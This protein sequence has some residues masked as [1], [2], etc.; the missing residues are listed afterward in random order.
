[1]F[2]NYIKNQMTSI[3][4]PIKT[5]VIA[6]IPINYLQIYKDDPDFLGY[7]VVLYSLISLSILMGVGIIMQI[8][9]K[10][11]KHLS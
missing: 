7:Q 9:Q 3:W 10:N 6:G 8:F 2:K 4:L 5:A 1:M 11:N